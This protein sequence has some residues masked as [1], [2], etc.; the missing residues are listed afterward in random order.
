MIGRNSLGA[1]LVALALLA[2][3]A[4]AGEQKSLGFSFTDAL[5]VITKPF[6]P[7]YKPFVDLQREKARAEQLEAERQRILAARKAR[8]AIDAR[9]NPE[10]EPTTRKSE[11]LPTDEVEGDGA[12]GDPRKTTPEA[13]GP[14][15]IKPTLIS[16]KGPLWDVPLTMTDIGWESL[17]DAQRASL[18]AQGKMQKLPNG[19]MGFPT[20]VTM[21]D[22]QGNDV[23]MPNPFV[24]YLQGEDG[25]PIRVY[26]TG[27]LS[28]QKSDWSS[29]QEGVGFVPL[30]TYQPENMSFDA[31]SKYRSGQGYTPAFHI[32][33]DQWDNMNKRFGGDSLEDVE[34][35]TFVEKTADG[36]PLHRFLGDGVK[37]DDGFTSYGRAQDRYGDADDPSAWTNY[38]VARRPGGAG[39]ATDFTYS[40]LSGVVDGRRWEAESAWWGSVDK[41]GNP[42]SPQFNG[43][44]WLDPKPGEGNG[45]IPAAPNPG[46]V[47]DPV[48]F[49]SGRWSNGSNFDIHSVDDGVGGYFADGPGSGSSAGA[50][51]AG[52]NDQ[53]SM[54]NM[55]STP[56]VAV[57]YSQPAV[58]E[59]PTD[60]MMS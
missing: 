27:L 4:H 24:Q 60:A 3:G 33:V 57:N 42:A 9:T 50:G 48:D 49:S 32:P 30:E 47:S 54:M 19:K 14:R 46:Q 15:R 16:T 58:S 10:E 12:G 34:D 8:E 55:G 39:N 40:N 43:L 11:G 22:D 37:G 1:A 52:T 28:G 7:L 45:G 23:Q 18:L 25:K 53:A 59:M 31:W 38:Q 17:T 35:R 56:D 41:D 44:R 26:D 5:Q 2:P 36:T 51:D 13:S 6:E 20:Y 29:Y 21:K